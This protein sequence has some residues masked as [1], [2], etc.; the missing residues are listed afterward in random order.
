V[1]AAQSRGL[2]L[3]WNVV[4]V[5]QAAT[6]DVAITRRRG[7]GVEFHR[8]NV[9][10]QFEDRGDKI[11]IVNG[12]LTTYFNNYGSPPHSFTSDFASGQ[13]RKREKIFDKEDSLLGKLMFKLSVNPARIP[14]SAVTTGRY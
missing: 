13:W 9:P 6:A 8:K 14:S 4:E 3:N 7:S 2:K 12:G 1:V 5:S 10:P 11:K